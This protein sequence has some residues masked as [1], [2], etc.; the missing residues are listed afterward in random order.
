MLHVVDH[1]HSPHLQRKHK[2]V[3][4]CL[5]EKAADSLVYTMYTV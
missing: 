3:M 1:Q 4:L 5:L 2:T